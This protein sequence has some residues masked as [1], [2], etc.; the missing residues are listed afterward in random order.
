MRGPSAS[1][2]STSTRPSLRRLRAFISEEEKK[3]NVRAKAKAQAKGKFKQQEEADEEEEE[4]EEDE[5]QPRK[6]KKGGAEKTT[7][8]A[9]KKDDD[10]DDEEDGVAAE[11][12]KQKK[13]AKAVC[14]KSATRKTAKSEGTKKGTKGQKRDGGS[15]LLLPCHVASRRGTP[16]VVILDIKPYI[17]PMYARTHTSRTLMW[18]NMERR[19]IVGPDTTPCN[20]CMYD[21]YTAMS[22]YTCVQV[23]IRVC[24][25]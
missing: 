9:T 12:K 2:A 11:D 21:L 3:E 20:A 5:Q 1:T 25:L 8:K 10:E 16:H 7:T 17:R 14:A 15:H 22:V 23:S 4:G 24:K 6:K 18:H 13:K 19:D